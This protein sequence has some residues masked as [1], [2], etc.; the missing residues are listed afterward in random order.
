[1]SDKA[2]LQRLLRELIYETSIERRTI[3]LT[4]IVSLFDAV[5]EEPACEAD[6]LRAELAAARAD[7][8]RLAREAIQDAFGVWALKQ[9]HAQTWRDMPE[10]YWMRG[11]W[12]EVGELAASLGGTHK[13][14]PEWELKQI[15]AIALN[16]LEY[17]ATLAAHD[18]EGS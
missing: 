15:A 8:D 13:H 1:M 6:I 7:A 14:P 5:R 3:I 4:Q 12:E 16:W 18:G 9:Q 10:T 17:R 11:L 2:T